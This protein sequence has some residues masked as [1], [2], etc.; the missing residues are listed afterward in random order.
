MYGPNWT[1][2]NT[3]HNLDR[4]AL[5][6]AYNFSIFRLFVFMKTPSIMN[7]ECKVNRE[8]DECF[9]ALQDVVSLLSKIDLFLR[10][11]R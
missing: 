11:G 6:C 5:L 9:T 8:C 3:F 7:G 1:T 10:K 4:F 2:R